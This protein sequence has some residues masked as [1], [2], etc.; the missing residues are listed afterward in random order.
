LPAPGNWIGASVL[1]DRPSTESF[2]S[3]RP[4]LSGSSTVTSI[5]PFSVQIVAANPLAKYHDRYN[6]GFITTDRMVQTL[7]N[8]AVGNDVSYE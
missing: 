3:P 6:W 4:S 1:R 7:Y 8:D 5:L 2:I